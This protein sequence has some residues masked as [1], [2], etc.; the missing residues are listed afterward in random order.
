MMVSTAGKRRVDQIFHLGWRKTG[1]D[2]AAN[3]TVPA[4]DDLDATIDNIILEG[5]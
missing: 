3:A 4:G 5:N 2:T 1:Y